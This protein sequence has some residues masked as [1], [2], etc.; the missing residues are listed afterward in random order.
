VNDI[1]V[2]F[3][4]RE[5]DSVKYDALKVLEWEPTGRRIR[6]RPRKRLMKDIEEGIQLM[7]IGR[8]RKLSKEWTDWRRIAE[9]AKTHSGL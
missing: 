1:D 2:K 9:K 3:C 8:W 7:R 6:G 4:V 5:C